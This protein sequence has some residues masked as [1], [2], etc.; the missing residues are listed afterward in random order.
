MSS[1]ATLSSQYHRNNVKISITDYPTFDGDPD[2]WKEFSAMFLAVASSHGFEY[3]FQ[4]PEY[5]PFTS[6]DRELYASDLAFTFDAFSY[7]WVAKDNYFIVQAAK[8]PFKSGRQVYLSAQS[9]FLGM[10]VKDSI[11]MENM[12]DL[13]NTTLNVYTDEGATGYN[14]KFNQ[15]VNT[16]AMYHQPFDPYLLKCIYLHNIKDKSYDVIKD[17]PNVSDLNLHELQAIVLQKYTST[18]CPS[19][20][21]D[22][23]SSMSQKHNTIAYHFERKTVFTSASEINCIERATN[24]AYVPATDGVTMP[25]DLHPIQPHALLLLRGSDRSPIT[26]PSG[27]PTCIQGS[28]YIVSNIAHELQ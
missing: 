8:T 6:L 26:V 21:L 2:S 14:N 19:T 17:Q 20:S 23:P 12:R 5:R 16:L 7:A 25:T 15:A 1:N 4:E 10:A 27:V 11:I 18:I 22:Q 24:I 13:I 3:V 9:Y 28:T